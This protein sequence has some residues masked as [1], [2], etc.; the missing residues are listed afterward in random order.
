MALAKQYNYTYNSNGT[1]ETCLDWLEEKGIYDR[2]AVEA[3]FVA[4]N[5]CYSYL[6]DNFNRMNGRRLT[7]GLIDWMDQ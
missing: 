6:N 5:Q 1:V 4:P 7:L 3:V 2:R